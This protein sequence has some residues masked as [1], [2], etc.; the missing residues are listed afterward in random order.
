MIEVYPSSR[1]R[2]SFKKLP[3][4]IQEKAERRDEM[5]R[6]NPFAP[7]L[8]S[9][10]LGGKLKEYWSY[11]VDEHYRVLFRFERRNTVIYFDIGTHDIYK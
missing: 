3:K 8:E 6:D 10:K 7:I 2:K 5:F 9:H 4:N 11:S 1:F